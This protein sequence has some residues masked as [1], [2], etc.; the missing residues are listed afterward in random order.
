MTVELALLVLPLVLLGYSAV[1]FARVVYQYNILAKATR[2]GVRILTGADPSAPANYPSANA[3]ERTVDLLNPDG[4]AAGVRLPGLTAG[5][6]QICTR[7]EAS[8]CGGTGNFNQ[9]ATGAGPM[10]LVRIQITGFPY[11][12]W[13]G[14][15]FLP[16]ITFGT[17]GTTMMAVR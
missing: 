7:I 1:E 6:V 8:A 9:V 11:E 13:F 16:S 14:T 10:D 12:P 4:S 15:T 3:I 2:D 5:L 17:I